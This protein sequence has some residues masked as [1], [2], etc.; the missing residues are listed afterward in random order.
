MN[1]LEY[2]KVKDFTYLEYCDYLQKKYGM[3]AYNYL[4]PNWNKN[5]KITRTKEGLVAH[6]KFEDHAVMLST[7]E[8]AMQ[9]PYEW[10]HKENIIY[11]DYLEHLFLH[12][13][14]CEYPAE[15][16]NPYEVVGL[17]GVINYIM[18][19]LNDLYSGWQTGQ[20]WRK[21]CHDKVVND[22]DVYLALVKRFKYGWQHS[23][24]Y[25]TEA[26]EFKYDFDKLCSSFNEQFGLWSKK[27]NNALYKEFKAL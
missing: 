25:F 3:S 2:E 24:W 26:E 12:I 5:P 15:D 14:I 11:C 16:R 8:Y 19:E 13:L 23:G 10:Q 20:A 1:F 22:K 27:D 7:A 6:H 18:P 17:G 4:T 21:V 9:N